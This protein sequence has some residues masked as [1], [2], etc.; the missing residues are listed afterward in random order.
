MKRDNARHALHNAKGVS[1]ARDGHPSVCP[2]LRSR[3]PQPRIDRAEHSVVVAVPQAS[4]CLTHRCRGLILE[5]RPIFSPLS[6]NRRTSASFAAAVDTGALHTRAATMGADAGTAFHGQ[7]FR[8]RIEDVGR[9][10]RDGSTTRSETKRSMFHLS[11]RFAISRGPCPR[12][13]SS[14]PGMRRRHR[15]S[16][17]Y[18][19]WPRSGRPH[20]AGST[21]SRR[22]PRG[23]KE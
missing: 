16:D 3:L 20:R 15:G 13:V 5:R 19:A 8:L 21:P 11:A 1:C 14:D 10:C 18:G 2:R 7:P 4:T 12:S 23:A 22:R 9:P 6:Q 17:R